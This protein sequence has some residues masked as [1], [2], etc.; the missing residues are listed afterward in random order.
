MP[1]SRTI[2]IL[3]FLRK[4]RIYMHIARIH[5]FGGQEIL[6]VNLGGQD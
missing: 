1:R 6:E 2:K 5:K 4:R 3:A